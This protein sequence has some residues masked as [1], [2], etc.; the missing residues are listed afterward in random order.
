MTGE[1]KNLFRKISRWRINPA[2]ALFL[3]WISWSKLF[4][5]INKNRIHV[6]DRKLLYHI[7][8][9]IIHISDRKLL[10]HIIKN[11]IHVSDRHQ[12]VSDNQTIRLHWFK[13]RKVFSFT[14][15][16]N[17]WSWMFVFFT[18]FSL[19]LSSFPLI[20]LHSTRLHR[21]MRIPRK[22]LPCGF[23]L[24]SEIRESFWRI[25]NLFIVKYRLRVISH[26]CYSIHL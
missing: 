7:N 5:Q 15:S 16:T 11:I 8:K 13:G 3:K 18:Q 20:R 21:A 17:L 9:N 6:S 24:M 14:F 1:K 2:V 23:W 22:L 10:Y 12:S 19:L 25:I 4:Y 26:W